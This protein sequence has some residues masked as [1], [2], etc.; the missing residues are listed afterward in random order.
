MIY[1]PEH[2][3]YNILGFLD[4]E[5]YINYSFTCKENIDHSN[6]YLK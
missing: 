4:V 2:V 3:L 5:S 1:I 6:N